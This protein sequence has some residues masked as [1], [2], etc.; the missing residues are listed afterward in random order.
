[1]RAPSLVP[2]ERVLAAWLPGSAEQA[3]SRAENGTDGTALARS[4][5]FMI[6]TVCTG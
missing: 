3:P 1:M 6:S 5:L 2:D 4:R